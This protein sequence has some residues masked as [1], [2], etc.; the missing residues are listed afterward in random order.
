MIDKMSKF[1]IYTGDQFFSFH[2]ERRNYKKKDDIRMRKQLLVAV[3]VAAF[4]FIIAASFGDQQE[5]G[6]QKGISPSIPL[7]SA[8][9]T[10]PTSSLTYTP[11]YTSGSK[12]WVRNNTQFGITP[13]AGF[14]EPFTGYSNGNNITGTGTG[15]TG[16]WSSTWQTQARQYVEKFTYAPGTDISANGGCPSWC[17]YNPGSSGLTF[18]EVNGKGCLN[19]TGTGIPVLVPYYT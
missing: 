13:N 5:R 12:N 1:G 3:V 18:K 19:K 8:D 4:V 10:A 6:T 7:A 17:N 9:L 16:S 11:L 14:D 2:Q 15:T